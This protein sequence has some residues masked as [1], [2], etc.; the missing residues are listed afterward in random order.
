MSTWARTVEPSH[1]HAKLHGCLF[2]RGAR[3]EDADQL[4]LPTYIDPGPH[5]AG[6][7]V[8]DRVLWSGTYE[9]LPPAS[10]VRDVDAAEH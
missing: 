7:L 6:Q 4:A 9:D 10:V 1:L 8:S 3:P 5:D 2:R